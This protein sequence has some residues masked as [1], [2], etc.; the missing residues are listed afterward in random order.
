MSYKRNNLE[1]S[2]FASRNH[3]EEFRY[4]RE[5]HNYA[6][7]GPPFGGPTPLAHVEYSVQVPTQ[8][9]FDDIGKLTLLSLEL[10]WSAQDDPIRKV[11][12]VEEVRKIEKNINARSTISS[13]LELSVVGVSLDTCELECP[14]DQV[15]D[16]MSI[17]PEELKEAAILQDEELEIHFPIVIQGCDVTGL[18]NPLD[19]MRPY[20]FF[21]ST[22]CYLMSLRCRLEKY[23]LGDDDTQPVSDIAHISIDDTY[24]PHP[25]HML[26]YKY[27]HH[28]KGIFPTTCIVYSVL[29]SLR[30][31]L[32]HHS[33]H[34]NQVRGD[35]PWDPGGFRS[36]RRGEAMGTLKEEGSSS[37]HERRKEE[38]S[39]SW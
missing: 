1:I 24:S 11:I 4:E 15:V 33:L 37:G 20:D 34:A 7:N 19:D 26:N 6:L 38:N 39:C 35:F 18:S 5:S 9:D 8:D 13:L 32:L 25:I 28:A 31:L 22:L 23:F 10:T 16:L 12:L 27:H 17:Y 29:C 3:M 30:F 36:W 21:A 14:S 2:P